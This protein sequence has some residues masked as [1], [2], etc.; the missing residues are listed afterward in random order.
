MTFTGG[1]VPERCA[2]CGQ[3]FATSFNE[4]RWNEC[5]DQTDHIRLAFR[6]RIEAEAVAAERARI[7]AA[8]EGL[9]LHLGDK[10]AVLTIIEGADDD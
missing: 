9:G 4:H 6:R 1:N 5:Q 2:W 3:T 8:V 7:R 10:L